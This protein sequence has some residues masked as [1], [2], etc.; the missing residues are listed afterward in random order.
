MQEQGLQNYSPPPAAGLG[1]ES[2]RSAVSSRL[3]DETL[4]LS[5]LPAV[6]GR[7]LSL[8]RCQDTRA[9][10]LARVIHSDQSLTS[11]VLKVAN[12]PAY[13]WN[14]QIVS[15]H[16]AVARLGFERIAEIALAVAVR[17]S[18]LSN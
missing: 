6:A 15:L 5:L 8:A 16:Q 11:H 7:V 2:F 4:E 9:A 14:A 1:L 13:G 12:S 10:E 18:P 3:D 17:R